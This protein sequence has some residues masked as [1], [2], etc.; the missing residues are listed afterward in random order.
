[1]NQFLEHTEKLNEIELDPSTINY[2]ESLI[3]SFREIEDPF[4]REIEE[5][6]YNQNPG[7]PSALIKSIVIKERDDN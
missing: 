7:D 4:E 1:M 6:N 2:K 3:E 5:I